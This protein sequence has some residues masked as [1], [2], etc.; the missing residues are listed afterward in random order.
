[1]AYQQVLPT[2]IEDP[3][4]APLDIA[5]SLNLIQQ[6]D[7]DF[8]QKLVSEAIQKNPDKVAAYRK[9]KKGLLGFFMGEIMRSSKGKADPKAAGELLEKLLS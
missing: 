9:G 8:L 3:G 2:M 6:S 5:Q 1:M 4:R 7:E